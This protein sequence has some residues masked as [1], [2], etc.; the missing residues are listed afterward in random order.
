MV[1]SEQDELKRNVKLWLKANKLD[2]AWLAQK[3]YVTETTVRNWMARKIIPAAKVY[4]IGE[5]IKQLPMALPSRLTVEEETLLTI[6]IDSATRKS[7]EK[8]AF[9]RGKTL[10]EFLADELPKLGMPEKGE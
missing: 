5:L 9:S 2:Y 8:K 6:K 4:I 3:C 10:S 7:L 1:E